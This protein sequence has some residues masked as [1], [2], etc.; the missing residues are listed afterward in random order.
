MQHTEARSHGD[1]TEKT[2]GATGPRSGPL[3]TKGA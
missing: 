2:P 3:T 1:D